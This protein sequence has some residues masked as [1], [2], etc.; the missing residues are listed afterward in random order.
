MMHSRS[1]LSGLLRGRSFFAFALT[2]V[3]VAVSVLP[4]FAAGGQKGNVNGQ[5]V[6][7]TT[8]APVANARITIAA[9]SGRQEAT[10]DSKGRFS[11]LGVVVDTYTLSV[12]AQG[13]TPF[14]QSGLTVIGDQNLEV[15]QLKVSKQLRTIARTTT[16]S[17][18]S[19]FQPNQTVD[20][21][22]VNSGRITQTTGKAESTN[23]N[24]LLLA[25]PGATLDVNN[26]ITIRGSLENEVGYQLDGIPFTEP[27]FSTNGSSNR[28]SGLSQVQVVEGAGDATQ[29]NVGGGV[30]NLIPKRG[31][32]PPFGVLDAE[33]GT[34]GQYSQGALEYGIASQSGNISNYISYLQT[35][36]R[37]LYG[38]ATTGAAPYGSNNFY[39]NSR[40]VNTDLID[41]LVLK[42]GKNL[43]QSFQVLYENRRLTAF[44]PY[45]GV[46]YGGTNPTA[47]FQTDPYQYAPIGLTD[48]L[49]GS[50]G[51]LAS[52]LPTLNGQASVNQPPPHEQPQID[53]QT[54]ALK[55]EYD[56]QINASNFLDLKLYNFNFAKGSTDTIGQAAQDPSVATVGGRRSGL[57]AD[58][59]HQF[60]PN[61]T[62]TFRVEGEN[63]HPMWDGFNPYNLAQLMEGTPGGLTPGNGATP[64]LAD[65]LSPGPGGVCPVA[66]GCYL[67][68]FF[69]AGQVPKLPISGINYNQALFQTFGIAIR[70]QINIRDRLRLDLGARY[71]GAIYRFGPNPFNTNP[72]DLNNPSDVPPAALAN[73]YINPRTVD[74]RAAVSYQMGRNDSLRFGYGRSTTFLNAQTAGTPAGLYNAE[75]LQHVPA[76]DTAAAP[77]CGSGTNPAGLFKCANYAQQLYWLYDQ[78][79]DAP[80]LG[81]A[82]A[83]EA[84][85][86]DITY[87]HQ[88]PNGVG[89][90]VTPFYKLSTGLPSF[91][92]LSETTDPVTGAILTEVFTANNN[93]INRT[94]GVEFGLTTPERAVGFDGFFSATYQNVLTSAPPL[95]N[96]EANLPII[97][98]GSLALGDVYRAGYVSPFVAR[99]GVEYKTKFGL[100]IN[101]ILQYDRGFPFNVG[102]TI[103]SRSAIFGNFQNVPQ[104]NVGPGRTTIPGFNGAT[105]G[106]L[107]TNYVDPALPGSVFNPNIA[108]T[109]GTPESSAA[110][111]ILYHPDLTADLTVEYKKGRNTFGVQ[112][113]NLFGN[114]YNG[115]VPGV[116][117]YYQ[118]VA[119]GVSGP[120]TSQV[121]QAVPDF[122]GGIYN[123]RGFANVP[124][125]ANAYTNAAYLLNPSNP[126]RFTF[127]YQLAL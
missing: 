83:Q 54:Q 22:T 62:F 78:N 37:I 13:Y 3:F 52:I 84:S 92:L 77:A 14:S 85:N 74:P 29:G 100:R 42:F 58:F 57:I 109:R 63:Q 82:T 60:T 9:P 46:S 86:Y 24:A 10:T 102:N 36:R 73:K 66:G 121:K 93:G 104:V 51:L 96:G 16:R 105:G 120:Q 68:Q 107:A 20:S 122:Q 4:S 32:F 39:N 70:N 53:D 124:A 2:L 69:P 7:A 40:D 41:N 25:V 108:A 119:T 19:A 61:Y 26:N 116:N 97:S 50:A 55:F 117:P 113:T 98:S 87:Q 106:A 111:G 80:D 94:S 47:Y 38:L 35:N 18:A 81:G 33:I 15:G 125:D 99:L 118:P 6:D 43:G 44:G 21:V 72:L 23:E 110:G 91:A 12:E 56:N 95:I 1:L 48:P 101:P 8:G 103:A 28:F 64:S 75:R 115:V 59:I 127:Y 27:F 123:N 30:V 88:F 11:F 67:S 65:F 31:T 76:L 126:T 34:P 45:G 17:I 79:F 49:N 89:L 71:D 5:I 112:A 114:I 90:R